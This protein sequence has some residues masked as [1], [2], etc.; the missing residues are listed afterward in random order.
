MSNWSLYGALS[1]EGRQ[2]KTP[3]L[4][5]LC[6][7]SIPPSPPSCPPR[8]SALWKSGTR[9]N[10]LGHHTEVRPRPPSPCLAAEPPGH[11]DWVRLDGVR[12]CLGRSPPS[13]RTSEPRRAC[14]ITSYSAP[15][16]SFAGLGY[17]RLPRAY[18]SSL[19]PSWAARFRVPRLTFAPPP[20]LPSV[21]VYRW[22]CRAFWGAV[23]TTW[24]LVGKRHKTCEW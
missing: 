3:S 13:R 19:R 22:I 18:F 9:A 23:A 6:H 24:S 16:P 7:P 2:K 20:P 12:H 17:P 8:P 10:A 21:C 1:L 15:G 4:S 5:S 11:P 14:P